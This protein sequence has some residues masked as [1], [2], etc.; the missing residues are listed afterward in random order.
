ML[1]HRHMNVIETPTETGRSLRLRCASLCS[2][3]RSCVSFR[4]DADGNCVT[5][6][7]LSGDE[8]YLKLHDLLLWL[9]TKWR[10]WSFKVFIISIFQQIWQANRKKTFCWDLR[11]SK[12][13]SLKNW[14]EMKNIYLFEIKCLSRVVVRGVKSVPQAGCSTMFY[15]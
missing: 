5:A 1:I 2:S 14:T 6:D 12:S 4:F 13:V 8:K 10:K 9:G 15:F 7:T 11:K 3:T